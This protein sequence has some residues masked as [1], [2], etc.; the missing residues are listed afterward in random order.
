MFIS[1]LFTV[2]LIKKLYFI[3]EVTISL[4]SIYVLPRAQLLFE[5]LKCC[6]IYYLSRFWLSLNPSSG[7][8]L[9]LPRSYLGLLVLHGPLSL[10]TCAF[11]PAATLIHPKH[12]RGCP[13]TWVVCFELKSRGA[14]LARVQK[15][16]VRHLP[17][18]TCRQHDCFSH[19]SR[20]ENQNKSLWIKQNMANLQPS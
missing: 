8:L 15:L 18:N 6:S 3:C 16:L 12:L 9:L 17:E 4:G 2:Q 1:R 20:E 7:I 14:P 19:I 11:V 10:T 5:E 13:A